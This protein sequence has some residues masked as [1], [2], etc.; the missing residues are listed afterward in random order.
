MPADRPEGLSRRDFLSVTG[1]LAGAGM[2]AGKSSAEDEDLRKAGGGLGPAP[3]KFGLRVNGNDHEVT[4][5]PRAT[6]LDVLRD[7]LDLTGAKNACDRGECGACTVIVDGKAVYACMMLAL[8]ARGREI[9]TIEGLAKG[10]DLH[11]VQAAFIEK[12]GYQCGYC[13][14]GQVMATVALLEKTP[15][16]SGDQIRAGLCGNLC[17]CAAYNRIFEAAASA[18]KAK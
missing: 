13:T 11:P 14:P 9:R 6:L 7:S 10:E 5:E 12:D 18:A 4:A 1:A 3:V 16:P 15:S 8:Q 17:R 2:L